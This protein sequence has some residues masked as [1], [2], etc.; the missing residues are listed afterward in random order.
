[1][2]GSSWFAGVSIGLALLATIGC[3]NAARPFP[4]KGTI[5]FEDG[6]PARELVN[7]LVAFDSPELHTSAVGMVGEDGTFHLKTWKEHDGAIPG[8]YRVILTPP[9][10]PERQ[11][12]RRVPKT[13]VI[14]SLI[15]PRYGKSDTTDLTAT[16]APHNNDITLRVKRAKRR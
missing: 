7:Y 10:P 1:M 5:L 15:D 3:G 2:P 16:V 9:L 8:S 12:D 6:Q 4:V 14:P 13:K 11:S